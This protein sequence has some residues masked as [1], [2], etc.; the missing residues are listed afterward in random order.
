LT[1]ESESFQMF[2][3]ADG[4]EAYMTIQENDFDLVICDIKMPKMDWVELL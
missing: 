4:Q 3:A 2:E 1:E